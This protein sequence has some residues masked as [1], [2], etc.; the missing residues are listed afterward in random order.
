MRE[1]WSTEK[2][3]M[4]EHMMGIGLTA[5]EIAKRMTLSKNAVQGKIHRVRIKLGHSPQHARKNNIIRTY[6]GPVIGKRAC[7]IC[8]KEFRTHS[9]FDRFCDPCRRRG[10]YG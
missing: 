2:T 4:L 6:K 7:N 10:V 9:R 1:A 5:S 8:Y 3:K